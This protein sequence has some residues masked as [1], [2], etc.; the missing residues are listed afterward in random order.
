MPSV[1]KRISL[2][3]ALLFPIPAFAQQ[4]NFP[5]GSGSGI[6]SGTSVPATC[7]G[8]T[9]FQLTNSTPPTYYDCINGVYILRPTNYGWHR[10]GTFIGTSL[11]ADQNNV[12]EIRTI[13]DTTCPLLPN[14]LAGESCFRHWGALGWTSGGVGYWESPTS[15]PFAV[16]RSGTVTPAGHAHVSVSKCGSTYFLTATNSFGVSTGI[17]LY[18][19]ASGNQ[20]WALLQANVIV[21]GA[22][23]QFDSTNLGNTYLACAGTLDGTANVYLYYDGFNGTKWAHGVATCTTSCF[24]GAATYTKSGSNPL[25]AETGTMGGCEFR[26]LNGTIVA[27]CHG[28]IIA[29]NTPSDLWKYTSASPTG[30]FTRSVSVPDLQRGTIDEGLLGTVGQ[31]Q[32]PT[33]LDVNGV[34]Y[35]SYNAGND[36]TTANGFFH[37]KWAVANTTCAAMA[38]TNGGAVEPDR[39]DGRA[40]DTINSAYVPPCPGLS[41]G[42]GTTNP[43]PGPH[44]M[45][46]NFLTAG[47]SAGFWGHNVCQQAGGSPTQNNTIYGGGALQFNSSATLTNNRTEWWLMTGGV[48]QLVLGAQ[49]DANSHAPIQIFAP[50]WL[51]TTA[52]NTDITGELAFSAATTATYTWTGVY[53]SHPECTATPQFDLTATPPRVWITYSTTVSFTINTSAAVT[54]SFSYHCIGRN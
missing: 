40:W 21:L 47:I 10:L 2:L 22:G 53:T 13:V 16:V 12:T 29:G 15:D 33:T 51:T 42:Y 34:C 37:Q 48:Q 31:I 35:L 9:S 54:G 30:P 7:S 11:A 17:D 44:L 45:A 19:S 23:G 1:L 52:S 46:F 26:L 38:L 28:Q 36:G 3:L 20:D 18:S 6:S 49:Y 41:I 43:A 32:K 27:R 8:A 39:F 25:I 24:G 5:S 14:L 4:Q 50:Y